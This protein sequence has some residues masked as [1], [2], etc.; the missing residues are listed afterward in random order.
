MSPYKVQN[1]FKVFLFL[2]VLKRGAKIVLQSPFWEKTN[3]NNV[4]AIVTSWLSS[5]HFKEKFKEL[6]KNHE[7]SDT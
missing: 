2:D 5:L 1:F 4:P 3:D 7:K 6:I